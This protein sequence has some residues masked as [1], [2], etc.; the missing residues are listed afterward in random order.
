MIQNCTKQSLVFLSTMSSTKIEHLV[1]IDNRGE[2]LHFS[3][4][5]GIV[6]L[7]ILDEQ[8]REKSKIEIP[9]EAW[10]ELQAK[11]DASHREGFHNLIYDCSN[12]LHFM[13]EAAILN[14][15]H[16]YEVTNCVVCGCSTV[17]QNEE[18]LTMCELSGCQQ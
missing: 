1:Q 10:Q 11:R 13:R 15:E 7:Q 14:M 9:T 6:T 4:E 2:L 3:I 16:G 17:I 12:Q 18:G 5:N 8:G